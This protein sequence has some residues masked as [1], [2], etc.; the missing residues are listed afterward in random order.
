[1][2]RPSGLSSRGRRSSGSSW[3][4]AAALLGLLGCHPHPTMT[5]AM[6]ARPAGTWKLAPSEEESAQT[7]LRLARAQDP[8][9][10]PALRA[11]L[12]DA[13]PRLRVLAAF[14]LGQLGLAWQPPSVE[15]RQD[16]EALLLARLPVEADAD[17]RDRIVE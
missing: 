15:A 6:P 5:T 8:A 14:S 9:S 1:M 12:A 11:A 10:L 3:P 13:R 16:A 7:L 17:V 4:A 2:P